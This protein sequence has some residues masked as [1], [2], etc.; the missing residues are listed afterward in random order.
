MRKLLFVRSLLSIDLHVILILKS[1][2]DLRS[3]QPIEM[4]SRITFSSRMICMRF[5]K[6]FQILQQIYIMSHNSYYC[7]LFVNFKTVVGYIGVLHTFKHMPIAI[8]FLIIKAYN[9]VIIL[10]VI[11]FAHFGQLTTER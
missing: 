11:C 1:L 7:C 3:S 6:I 5:T 10:T 9:I 8:V 2:L 4:K